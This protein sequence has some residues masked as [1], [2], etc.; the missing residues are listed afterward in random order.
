MAVMK[1]TIKVSVGMLTYNQAAYVRKAI[2]SIFA[3]TYPIDEFIIS[4]DCSTDATYEAIHEAVAACQAVPHQVRRCIV[5]RNEKNLGLIKHFNQIV[6]SFSNDFIVGNAGDDISL[7]NR[8]EIIVKDY[9]RLGTPRYFLCHSPVRVMGSTNPCVWIPPIVQSRMDIAQT[10]LAFALH[11]GATQAY[12]RSLYTDFGPIRHETYEDLILGFRA[13]LM[14]AYHY[15]DRPLMLYRPGGISSPDTVVPNA[16]KAQK[17]LKE[18]LLQRALDAF[19]AGRLDLVELLWRHYSETGL[20]IDHRQAARQYPEPTDLYTTYLERKVSPFH[21]ADPLPA[22]SP[23]FEFVVLCRV[24]DQEK[25]ADTF[26]SLAAQS[27]ALWRLTVLADFPAP[28]PALEEIDAL[29]WLQIG[30]GEAWPEQLEHCLA[31]TASP[32][33][34]LIEPGVRFNPDAV[35]QLARHAATHP[36]WRLIYADSDRCGTAEGTRYEPAFRPDFNLD[37]LRSMPYLGACLWV[38]REAF[39]AAGGWGCGSAGTYDLALRVLDACGEPAIGHI[40]EVLYHEPGAPSPP[41]EAAHKQALLR[42]LQRNHLSAEVGDGYLPGTWRVQYGHEARPRVSILIPTKDQADL[43]KACVA[44]ILEK[45]AYLDYEILIV[46]NGSTQTAAREYL[47]SLATEDARVKVL[48]YPKPFNF[49]AMCNL[50]ARAS[51]G[52][53]LLLLNNDTV[54]LQADWLERMLAYGQR[55]D[56]GIVG[57]KLMF[58]DTGTVQHAGFIMG[59]GGIAEHPYLGLLQLTEGGY[60]NRALVDQNLSAVTG[61]SLMIRRSIWDEVKG[62]DEQDFRVSYNDIDLCLKV[63]EKGYKILWT[64]HV[65][66]LHHGSASQRAEAAN[67]AKAK[68]AQERFG[69]EQRAMLRRWLPRIAHDSAYNRHLSLT[70]RDFRVEA[71]VVIDWNPRLPTDKTRILGWTQVGGSIDYRVK[72][73]LHALWDAGVI[74]HSYIHPPAPGKTRIPLLAEIARARPDIL[75]SVAFLEIAD[76]IETLKEIRSFTDIPFVLQLDDLITAIPR[77]SEAYERRNTPGEL[78][79]VVSLADRVVTTT[80]PIAESIRGYAKEVLVVP[81]YLPRAIW[82]GLTSRR[83]VGAKPR[84][85]W[86]GAMQHGGDL[87]LIREVIRGTFEEVDWVFLG[88]C[89]EDLTPFVKEFHPFVP[90]ADYPAK[91]ASLNLDL[92]VAP[93]ESNRFNEC[94]SNLRLLEYGILG[95]PVVCSDVLPYREAPVLRVPNEPDAWIAAI[96]ERM[97]DLDAAEWE[98]DALRTWVR[99]HWMLEDHLEEWA[100]GYRL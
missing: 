35:E 44:S 64:P 21:P 57:V 78:K 7:P 23:A 86:A 30:D 96:R 29:R 41:D 94:K 36:E 16:V 28:D 31:T 85:G 12:T 84:V 90:F 25:L 53:Y 11:I 74:E 88:M 67:P 80:Q 45:T 4:D 68:K 65:V 1:E 59:L 26:D 99:A 66:L 100:W 89:S 92:A 60:M 17:H 20:A 91:L 33:L 81:N 37:L 40:D 48:S 46:D 77:R 62:L 47:G 22:D 73:P 71:D 76:H 2:E 34:C 51:S 70:H 10:A 9:E 19:Q 87:G 52:D 75:T 82:D 55:P 63:G 8:T 38:E 43:L 5:R 39:R 50:A 27:A 15:I 93:L 72:Q 13:A 18:T 49:S 98:G 3:Q 61:A 97:H 56:I 54:V 42:H 69:N 79:K 24:E 83:R 95:W 58:P 32:W 6:E 14:G